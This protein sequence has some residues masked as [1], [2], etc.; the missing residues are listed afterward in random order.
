[1]YSGHD[2]VQVLNSIIA[3]ISPDNP[4]QYLEHL[5]DGVNPAFIDVAL[6]EGK[7]QVAALNNKKGAND[8]NVYF[9]LGRESAN[10]ARISGFF[11]ALLWIEDYVNTKGDDNGLTQDE[12]KT[13]TTVL[14]KMHLPQVVESLCRPGQV[15]TVKS[16]AACLAHYLL[17]L[18]KGSPANSQGAEVMRSN[19]EV[20]DLITS[21][22]LD[23]YPAVPF[24]AYYLGTIK[25]NDDTLTL[26][27]KLYKDMRFDKYVTDAFIS[28]NEPSFVVTSPNAPL[29]STVLHPLC[30]QTVGV[31]DNNSRKIDWFS[32]FT[33][34]KQFEDICMKN[35]VTS[36]A[37]AKYMLQTS[38][39]KHEKNVQAGQ[40]IAKF[41]HDMKIMGDVYERLRKSDGLIKKA[42]DDYK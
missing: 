10:R 15:F 41:I 2:L 12:K 4:L 9:T 31:P 7:K 20:S 39:E 19:K 8:M 37:V 30:Y 23:S 36:K 27:E 25:T 24:T 1:M 29:V 21:S 16:Y 32:G 35:N 11:S 40:P 18:S 3:N 17:W 42:S 14:R 33:G 13:F 22:T 26:S 5:Y 38:L 34:T 28:A 6:E